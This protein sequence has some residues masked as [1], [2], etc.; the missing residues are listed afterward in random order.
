MEDYTAKMVGKPDSELLRYI[1]HRA[2]YIEAAVLAALAELERRG[3]TVLGAPTLRAE[4]SAAIQAAPAVTVAP[5]PW[6]LPAEEDE[7]AV[8]VA[9]TPVLYSPV[10]VGIYSMFSALVGSVLM[11][12]NLLRLR[13]YDGAALLMVL[14]VVVLSTAGWLTGIFHLTLLQ[15]AFGSNLVMAGINVLVLWRT[16]IGPQPYRSRSWVNPLLVI[17]ALN[18]VVAALVSYL[19]IPLPTLPGTVK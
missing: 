19:G 13:R 12:M 18:F 8:E 16:F 9:E 4:L 3:H 1:E 15:F 5:P 11:L 10:T 2:E 14:F 7:A 6:A 17:L